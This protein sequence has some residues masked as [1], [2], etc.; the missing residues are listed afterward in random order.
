MG[1]GKERSFR[2][3]GTASLDSSHFYEKPRF[4]NSSTPVSTIK[5]LIL[6]V[7]REDLRDRDY[8]GN[9]IAESMVVMKSLVRAL[10]FN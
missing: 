3:K 8:E 7:T 10:L 6:R 5:R 2:A 9:K 4:V 1:R